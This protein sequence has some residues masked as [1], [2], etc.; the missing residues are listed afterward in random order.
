M[1]AAESSNV[2]TAVANVSNFVSSSTSVN[3]SAAQQI[4]NT[5]QLKNNCMLKLAND[6]DAKAS[7]NLAQKNN[8]IVAAKQDANVTNNI[9]Q[10]MLQQAQ[11]TVGSLGIGYA[12]AHNSASELVNATTQVVN[13]MTVGCSQYSSV[14]NKFTCDNSTIVAKNLNIGF[15]TDEQFI[16]T[17][18]LNNDQVANIVNDVSQ[19]I[20]QKATAT[21]EGISG[22]LLM[23]LLMI[24]LI[25]YVA[26]KPLSSGAA[27]SIVTVVVV[28][29][30]IVVINWMYLRGTPPFFNDP[31][32][33]INNSSTGMGD[34]D[35]CTEM[36]DGK[37][38]LTNPPL[39]YIYALTPLDS[40]QPGSN[41]VQMAIAS[42]SGQNSNGSSGSNG[43]YRKDT[44]DNLVQAMTVNLG[45][46]LT[47]TELA[48]RL[49]IPMIPNPLTV[50]TD[51]KGKMY[52]IPDEYTPANPQT[53]TN[54][55]CTPGTVQ[56]GDA[57]SPS[58]LSACPLYASPSALDRTYDPEN[59]ISNLNTK[60]WS[61]YVY[62]TG[63]YP[64]ARGG[65][66][67]SP[68]DE[69][70][71]RALFARFVLSDIVDAPGLDLHY[72]VLG[73]EYVKFTD[74]MNVVTIQLAEDADPSNVY[75]YHPYNAPASWSNGVIGPGYISGKVGRVDDSRY[76]FEK[77]MKRYGWIILL[78]IFGL[79]VVY[80]A[81]MHFSGGK[82][83]KIESSSK[84][85]SDS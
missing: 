4:A 76:R 56:V 74:S 41:L 37:I 80:M 63:D 10:E 72:H 7:S 11:S 6:L 32:Q 68:D 58:D 61:D 62:M 55:K 78:V 24:A 77:F 12:S 67:G 22:V 14:D 29:L 17:Q 23:I 40:S 44:Y 2:A 9:A 54:S 53:G 8:Q 36:Q 47:Y 52:K 73:K 13:A 71:I 16:S 50:M 15:Q 65:F 31:R 18:T 66:T 35:T 34:S 42:R 51:D 43:G 48:N 85:S 20:Q 3:A 45:G 64:P 1:G 59:A 82:G 83:K 30:F 70:V 57:S 33:C 5:I 46:G 69:K 21:V 79:I 27:K 49:Q 75:L 84:T 60:Q 19:S 39:K 28:V 81:Y 38:R 26:T 25:I